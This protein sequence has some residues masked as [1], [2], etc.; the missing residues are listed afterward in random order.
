[1]KKPDEETQKKP[2]K[3]RIDAIHEAW[4]AAHQHRDCYADEHE[5]DDDDDDD[6]LYNA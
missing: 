3:S 4:Y 1:M 2:K 5:P 6:D